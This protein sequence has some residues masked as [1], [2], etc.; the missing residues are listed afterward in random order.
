MIELP[1]E[2][3]QK[4]HTEH[5]YI[6]TVYLYIYKSIKHCL[7]IFFNHKLN[8]NVNKTRR[9]SITKKHYCVKMN[10]MKCFTSFSVLIFLGFRLGTTFLSRQSS[11]FPFQMVKLVV[12]KSKTKKQKKLKQR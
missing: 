4:S 11:L 12:K 9:A 2:H 5:L 1:N 6:Y 7:S 10:G 3:T 8:Q